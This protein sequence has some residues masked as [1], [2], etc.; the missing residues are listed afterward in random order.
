M[1]AVRSIWQRFTVLLSFAVVVYLGGVL[2]QS[3]AQPQIQPRLELYQTNLLLHAAEWQALNQSEAESPGVGRVLWGGDPFAAALEQYQD[4]QVSLEDQQAAADQAPDPELINPE[5]QE[6]VDQLEV[7]LR[8]LDLKIGLLQARQ[9]EL[10]LAQE[11]WQQ[12]QETQPQNA[13]VLPLVQTAQVLAGLWS[14][15]VWLLPTAEAQIQQNL[16]GWFRYQGL[17]RLYQIQQ[18][19]GELAQLQAQ[20]RG[21]M[22]QAIAK[23]MI[24]ETLPVLVSLVGLGLLVFLVVQR[25]R[26]GQD[27]LLARNADRPWPTPWNW[28]TVLQV[29]VLG[30]FVVGQLLGG[31]IVVPLGFQG[32]LG[33]D[34]TAA[35]GTLQALVVLV[36]YFSA[37]GGTLLILYLAL[38]PFLPL[39]EGWFRVQWRGPWLWWALGGY[40]VALP[41]VI[42]VSWFNQAFWQ[43]EGGSN[44]LLSLALDDPNWL[45]LVIFF[46]MA[47]IAAPIFEEILF[48]GFLLPSLTR[49]VPVWGAIGLS[50]LF[51]AVA[52]LKLAQ[53]LPLTALGMVLGIV[54]TRSRNL[55]APMLLHSLWNGATLM[56]LFILGSGAE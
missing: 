32:L 36:A 46:T 17:A 19:P 27:S 24:V 35:T 9:G 53:V 15:P 50:S 21:A 12:I 28:E 40:S 26:Q 23:L 14:D 56:G 47:A 54:Y 48:R 11:R 52:H 2:L 43:G 49:Y 13:E 42:L 6:P 8:D 34:P 18:R 7:L 55:L 51:F 39:P 29:V 16:K 44:P 20:E 37:A 3:V 33:I 22:E 5:R 30:F 10:A 31:Q 4:I 41:L 25:C 45:T 38:K 1:K